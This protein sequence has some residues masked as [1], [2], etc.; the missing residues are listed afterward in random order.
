MNCPRCFF[1]HSQIKNIHSVS[2][3]IYII[4]TLYLTCRMNCGF[5]YTCSNSSWFVDSSYE[6]L[7][8]SLYTFP[9]IFPTIST[10]FLSFH[11][12]SSF[13]FQQCLL[14]LVSIHQFCQ[15]NFFKTLLFCHFPIWKPSRMPHCCLQLKNKKI[16]TPRPSNYL[17]LNYFSSLI[18]HNCLQYSP[19]QPHWL[20]SWFLNQLCVLKLRPSLT[21][22]PA[23]RKL[24]ASLS[25]S[26]WNSDSLNLSQIT[27]IYTISVSSKAIAISVPLV[28]HESCIV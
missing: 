27:L 10:R 15:A 22:S 18:S 13:N 26:F 23:L 14:L 3:I 2:G 16:V 5:F 24:Q 28:G 8:V 19:L 11:N 6:M 25:V 12:K 17:A 21:I 1:F 20:I 7:S 4:I 9:S